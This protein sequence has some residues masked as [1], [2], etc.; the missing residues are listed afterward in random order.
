MTL[1]FGLQGTRN[2]TYKRLWAKILEF[3]SSEL[4]TLSPNHSYHIH[5]I[6]VNNYAYVGD[7]VSAQ[8]VIKMDPSYT[9]AKPKMFPMYYTVGLQKNSAYTEDINLV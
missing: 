6:N 4:Y 7:F 1:P 8:Q 9:I 5:M 3:N 2:P